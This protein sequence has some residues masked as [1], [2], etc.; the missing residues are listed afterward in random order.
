MII[1]HFVDLGRL[2]TESK[3]DFDI[4]PLH[5]SLPAF[6]RF[7]GVT[8]GRFAYNFDMTCYF[9]ILIAYSDSP[10]QFT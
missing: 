4:C 1:M 2:R 3:L 5:L 6:S 9:F 7:P 10:H 8:F